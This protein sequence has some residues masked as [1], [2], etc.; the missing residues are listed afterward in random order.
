[1]SEQNTDVQVQ[2]EVPVAHNSGKSI[3]G[4]RISRNNAI[5]IGIAL[6]V[7]IGVGAYLVLSKAPSSPSTTLPGAGPIVSSAPQTSIPG[8][9][10]TTTAGYQQIYGSKDPFVSLESPSTTAATTTT[11][12]GTGSTSTTLFGTGSTSTTL[13]TPSSTTSSLPSQL[14]L[15]SVS[16]V[17]QPSSAEVTVNGSTYSGLTPG[18]SFGSS[19]VITAIN[20]SSGCAT[21]T[22][23]GTN[24]FQ[25]CLN[26]A[27]TK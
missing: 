21:F 17:G 10:T 22:N 6:I 18:Q 3:L 20:Q 23:G 16:P 26:Q 8:T 9:T 25:I 11:L 14:V 24:P 13:V 1:M 4:G 19:F 27:V 7:I 2:N 15:V 12:F 5:A